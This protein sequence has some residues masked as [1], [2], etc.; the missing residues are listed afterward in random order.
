M[1]VLYLLIVGLVLG[2]ACGASAQAQSSGDLQQQINALQQQLDAL[3][4]GGG[5]QQTQGSSMW[6]APQGGRQA[7]QAGA[8]GGSVQLRPTATGRTA[9]L[10]AGGR[11]AAAQGQAGQAT[12]GSAQGAPAKSTREQQLERRIEQLRVEQAKTAAQGMQGA[13]QMG[14][15]TEVGVPYYDPYADNIVVPGDRRQARQAARQTQQNQQQPPAT[16]YPD[17]YGAYGGGYDAYGTYGGGYD[18]YGNAIGTGRRARGIRGAG[19]GATPGGYNA[20]AVKTNLA[21]L[22]VLAPNLG[23]EFGLARKV[24]LDLAFQYN[25]WGRAPET[26]TIHE[27]G[28]I[29][30]PDGT[31]YK[32]KQ[33]DHWV[34]KAEVRLWLMER[35]RGQFLGFHALYSKY[36]VYGVKIPLLFEKD[37]RYDGTALGFGITYGYKWEWGRRAGLEAT[38]GLGMVSMDYDKFA[39]P[40]NTAT[41]DV[42]R[43][44]KTYFGPTNIGARVY[45][46]LK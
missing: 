25:G 44:K 27:S 1:R 28:K 23:L 14:Q 26:L 37:L 15:G 16:G 18:A 40:L 7:R 24:S 2:T 4:Q 45:F 29:I 11:S 6:G 8:Q 43:F 22:A 17:A 33:T 30:G 46:M 10:R 42:G 41:V 20:V 12:Q 32:D 34:G 13:A 3:K 39:A 9:N 35:M 5:Q 38:I 31:V 19:N 36:D 21:S